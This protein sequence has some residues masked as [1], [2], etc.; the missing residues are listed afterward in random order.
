MI[1][2]VASDVLAREALKLEFCVGWGA[3]WSLPWS[4]RAVLVHVVPDCLV[5]W[6]L[7]CVTD[8]AMCTSF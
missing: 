4:P 3:P 8:M 7:G 5:L 2:L 6:T 1:P